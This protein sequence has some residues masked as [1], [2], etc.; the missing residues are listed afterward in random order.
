MLCWVFRRRTLDEIL[1]TRIL[2]RVWF[3]AQALAHVTWSSPRKLRGDSLWTPGVAQL[4]FIVD[5]AAVAGP[6]NIEASISN[7]LYES[8]VYSIRLG[9]KTVFGDVFSPKGGFSNPVEWLPREFNAPPDTVCNWVLAAG[10]DTTGFNLDHAVHTVKASRPVQLHLTEV[11]PR[12][13]ELQHLL[14]TRTT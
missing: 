8:Y 10:A 6:A 7:L 4:E 5:N 13:S 1:A 9:M 12:A 14:C 3:P 11:T 2:R